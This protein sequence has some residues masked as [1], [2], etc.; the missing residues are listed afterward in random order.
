[1]HNLDLQQNVEKVRNKKVRKKANNFLVISTFLGATP[2]YQVQRLTM[3]SYSRVAMQSVSKSVI[4]WNLCLSALTSISCPTY[5]Y[6]RHE[7]LVSAQ[8]WNFKQFRWFLEFWKCHLLCK[9]S[10]D[11]TGKFFRKA[12][13]DTSV[14]PNFQSVYLI[15]RLDNSHFGFDLQISICEVHMQPSLRFKTEFRIKDSKSAGTSTDVADWGVNGDLL[16]YAIKLCQR[17]W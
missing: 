13:I 6:L 10:F 14:I 11:P 15:R 2:L 5:M 12:V 1:M 9:L 3:A 7:S 16:C 8:I 4:L 17:P